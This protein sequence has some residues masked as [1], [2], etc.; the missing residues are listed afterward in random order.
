MNLYTELTDNE[1]NLLNKLEIIENREYNKEDITWSDKK[2][3]I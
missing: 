1:I 3:N 2:R